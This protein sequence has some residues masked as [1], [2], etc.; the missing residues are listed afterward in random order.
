MSSMWSEKDFLD[1][2]FFHQL[3]HDGAYWASKVRSDSIHFFSKN[4]TQ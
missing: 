1:R 4:C 2:C 3:W